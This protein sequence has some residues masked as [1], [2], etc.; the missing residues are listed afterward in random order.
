MRAFIAGIVLLA[1]TGAVS[2]ESVAPAGDGMPWDL[3]AIT[4]PAVKARADRLYLATQRLGRYLLGE[5]HP[6]AEDPALLLLTP[7]RSG[8]HSV[9]PNAGTAAG[10]AFLYR[11]GDYDEKI[12]GISRAELLRSKLV[13]MMR[14]L[15]AT[16]VTGSRPTSDGKK[17]G[18]AWQSAH[19]AETLGM[20]AWWTGR[21]LPADVA[22]DVRRV[23]AHEAGRFVNAEPPHQIEN[24]TKA[25]ENA[26]NCKILSAAIVLMPDDPRR[27]QWE[28]AFHK[29]ALSSW[30]RPADEHASMLVDGRP[31]SQQ[32]TGANIHDDYTLE[33][34]HIVHPD[35]MTAWSLS[36]GCSVEFLLTHRK[37]P[38]A[39]LHNVAGIYENLKWFCLPDGGFVYPSGQDWAVY[40]QVDWL[41]PNLLAAVCG[42]DAEAW[43][44]LDRSLDVLEKMQA[45][46]PEGA[47]YLP[48]ENFFA[49]AHSDKISQFARGWLA[50][51]FV[52]DL[53]VKEM[54]RHGVR[55]LDAARIILN[56]TPSAVHAISWGHKIMAQCMPMQLDRMISPHDRSGVGHIVL[57]AQDKPAPVSLI[58]ARIDNDDQTFSAEL[59]IEHGPN[60]IR[61]ELQFRSNADGSFT[62]HERLVAVKDVSST[63]IAT[64]L[65]GLLNNPRWIYERGRRDV[66]IGNDKHVI[67]AMSGERIENDAATDI[68]IDDVL[69]IAGVKPLRVCYWAG[70]T[71]QRSRVTD[72][73]FL[74]YLP[75][76]RAW[77]AGQVIS[78]WEA[79]LRCTQREP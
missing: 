28:K 36:L 52:Q 22:A 31:I 72:T 76:E 42:R 69:R 9:R 29:W 54:K 13:P 65:I 53:Q 34:H 43:S 55:R 30:L 19:W 67:P 41:Y 24:D 64:G 68:V 14:Y 46:S 17:W 70:T 74:N 27:G 25:E 71:P 39:L 77:K 44:L 78:E 48:E 8:E 59:V 49:S 16:H 79:T 75:G 4:N 11:F 12:V 40:R 20:A 1:L 60:T 58:E 57:A 38:E 10:L 18:D 3:P 61:A 45:R 2:G 50:L 37:P 15:T 23:V 51:H 62:I 6:W 5:L 47:I 73:L 21:D 32:F 66:R 63:E 35:Y 56:R 33:N 7:S 26:W